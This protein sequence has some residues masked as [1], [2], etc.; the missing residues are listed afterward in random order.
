MKNQ[1]P[2]SLPGK[3]ANGLPL[4]G[5]LTHANGSSESADALRSTPMARAGS[6]VVHR[7]TVYRRLLGSADALAVLFA[8]ALSNMLFGNDRLELGALV[9]PVL[10]VGVAKA[11]GL[12]DRDA[13][14]LHKATLDELPRIIGVSNFAALGIWL[15]DGT[16][17]TG[18]IDRPQLVVLWIMLILGILVARSLARVMARAI[19]PVERCLFVGDQDAADEF[20]ERLALTHDAKAEMVACL[21]VGKPSTSAST[22]TG[23]IDRIKRAVEQREVDRVVMAARQATSPELIDAVR[24]LGG[25]SLKVSVV[26]DTAQIVS[27]SSELDRLSGMTLFG[28]R[29]FEITL[30]SRLIKRAFDLVGSIVCLV[31]SAPVL[32]VTVI[33]IRLDTPGPI[34]YRQKRAGRHGEPFEMIKL[35]SMVR[36]AEER[37]DE[38]QH[39]NEAEGVFKMDDDPRV[40]RV[41]RI[42]RSLHID[43]LPQMLNVLRGEMSL[44][45]P[46]PLPLEEDSRIEGWHRRRLDI[47]PG[48]TG[49]W[50]VLGSSRIPVREM[51]K[52][53][54]KYVADWSLWNDIRIVLLTFGHVARRGGR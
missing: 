9:V 21:E 13:Y 20:R 26:S 25:N 3:T 50:Q 10:F 4:E 23:V 11:I 51:V 54:Y 16:V 22:P 29:R 48:V 14:L 42:I 18:T 17:I 15:A 24:R 47:R 43:E 5:R 40:T 28:I 44:V 6:S 33:A 31:L 45:G 34:L 27:S 52:L 46:R 30:S 37:L 35:R 53:D 2:A 12:Y 8:M 41:G 38:V 36:D 39:L 32:A 19:S 7:E 49:P 1:E